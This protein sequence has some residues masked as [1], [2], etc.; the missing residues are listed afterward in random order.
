M[1]ISYYQPSVGKQK[2][3]TRILKQIGKI[4]KP[5]PFIHGIKIDKFFHTPFL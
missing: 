5:R 1:I 2:I 4:K 3:G